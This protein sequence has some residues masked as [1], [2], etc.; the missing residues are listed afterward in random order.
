[1]A[2]RE[3]AHAYI[4]ARGTLRLM[5]RSTV[6]L[7]PG[8]TLELAPK[9]RLLVENGSRIVVHTGATLKGTRKQLRKLERRG[10]IL[11]A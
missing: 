3:G 9:A 11:R 4:E 2:L 10:R 1:M 5:N 8:A 6:H 7:L